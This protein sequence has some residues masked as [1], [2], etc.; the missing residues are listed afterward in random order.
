[1]RRSNLGVRIEE[2]DG[3]RELVPD[4]LLPNQFVELLQ[5]PAERSPELR[6]MVEVLDDAL[7]TFCGCAGSPRRQHR[8]QRPDPALAGYARRRRHF[9]RGIGTSLLRSSTSPDDRGGAD[10][11][12]RKGEEV[13]GTMK[14]STILMM[15]A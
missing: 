1:M 12:I 7:R 13:I 15:V 6:L 11:A 5:G 10:D 3:P 4:G 14:A 2:P 8:R 9:C